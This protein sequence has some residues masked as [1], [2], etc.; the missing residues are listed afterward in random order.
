[1]NISYFSKRLL[2]SIGCAVPY[3]KATDNTKVINGP[4]MLAAVEKV[5]DV[6]A[7]PGK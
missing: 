1:M 6:R 4:R 3:L 5:A 7:S 2:F